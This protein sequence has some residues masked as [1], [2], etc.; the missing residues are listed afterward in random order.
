VLTY[1]AGFSRA[2]LTPANGDRYTLTNGSGA[3]ART[4][5]GTITVNGTTYTLSPTEFPDDITVEVADFTVN[6]SGTSIIAMSG[7]VTWTNGEQT[8]TVS[9]TFIPPSSSNQGLTIVGIPARYNGKGTYFTA[10]TDDD[11]D[12]GNF[13]V[14]LGIKNIQLQGNTARYI[15]SP[16]QG[17][18]VTIPILYSATGT[19][20][21]TGYQNWTGSGTFDTVMVLILPALS[22]T[23]EELSGIIYDYDAL[24]NGEIDVWDFEDVTFTGGRATVVWN[25]DVSTW[26]D[27][28]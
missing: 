18:S 26:D 11:Y 12:D 22:F 2:V 14:L 28:D 13:T 8:Q 20:G 10:I 27:D 9:F 1:D 24:E 17:G 4:S 7:V 21:A 5:R 23:P 15:L 25:S 19:A 3:S 16:I 6:V